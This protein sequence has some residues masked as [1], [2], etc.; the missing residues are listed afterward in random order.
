MAVVSF[1]LSV[2]LFGKVIVVAGVVGAVST[3]IIGE[4][5]SYNRS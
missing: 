2:F 1:L 3:S 4:S 5:S